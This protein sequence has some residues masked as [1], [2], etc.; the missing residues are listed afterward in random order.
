MATVKLA[1]DARILAFMNPIVEAFLKDFCGRQEIDPSDRSQAF[2]AFVAYC[3]LAA[4]RLDQGDF[5]DSLTDD[6]EEGLDSVA[7]VVNGTLAADPSD[8]EELLSSGSTLNVK[9][10]FTQAKTSEGWDGGDVLK[11]T[12]AVRGFFDGTDIGTSSVVEAA[13]QV[14][15]A[16]LENVPRLEENPQI[17]ASFASTGTLEP[18]TAAE[19]HMGELATDLKALALFSSVRCDL[20]DGTRLQQLYRSATS[21]AVATI[22]FTSKVTLPA[23]EGVEQ[24]Y[25]GVLPAR[26]LMKLLIDEDSGEIRRSVFE[27]NV[28]DFQGA[29]APVNS[30]IRETL[31]SD[32]RRHFAVLN[33]GITIVVRDL[34]VTANAFRLANYQIVNG[35]QTSNVLFANRDVFAGDDDV[36]VPTRLIQTDDEDLI[37][38]IVTATNSQTEVRVE[39]L[40]ARAVAERHVETFFAATEPPRNLLYERRSKQYEN[41]GDV[42]K[43]RVID[44]YTLVRA[45]AAVFSDEA[46][47]STGYPMQLLNRLA[48]ARR[49]DDGSQRVLLF[50]DSD[51]PIV[52]YAAA[53]AY[54]RL[55][56]FFKTSRL[57]AK[58]KPARW[59]LLAAARHLQLP[60][61]PPTF[62][63]K[64]FRKWVQ[65]FLAAVWDEAD[66]PALFVDAAATIDRAGVSLSRSALRNAS[67]TQ[68]VL[69]ALAD[70]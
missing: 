69:K 61:E 38:A 32:G 28:R 30:R 3:I 47:L 14:H 7:I 67:A 68:D 8:I 22:E 44:R 49:P 4:E 46:H 70:T 27:D 43:A 12:R 13:R 50:G 54:Y 24:A 56:L 6:G 33:N 40:N 63:D 10:V 23:I 41:K 64:R 29:D 31:R 58:Y 19:K 1:A 17:R 62:A 37:T 5:R 52:Y 9:Y 11:F 39:Q 35:A 20:V 25:L 21:T 57:D 65:P 36:L 55:D 59:H 45:T 60:E 53:S 51:E 34:R 26:E 2:E 66:G 18:G 15:A 48:G 16:I 42:V